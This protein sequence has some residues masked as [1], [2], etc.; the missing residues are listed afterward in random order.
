V[1]SVSFFTYHI[2]ARH[3][4]VGDERGRQAD[5]PAP[6]LAPRAPPLPVNHRGASPVHGRGALDEADRRQ[7][8]VVGRAPHR[9]GFRRVQNRLSASVPRLRLLRRPAR[10]VSVWRQSNE[11]AS[12]GEVIRVR[13]T[14]VAAWLV[15]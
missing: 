14:R 1:S 10:A 7:R 3:A 2:A 15:L 6:H 13:T 4:E 5:A 8:R 12:S 11:R 9:A